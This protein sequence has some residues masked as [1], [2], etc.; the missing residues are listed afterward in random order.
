MSF[1]YRYRKQIIICLIIF[2]ILGSG[3]GGLFFFN[4]NFKKSVKKEKVVLSSE[5][6]PAIKKTA[7]NKTDTNNKKILKVDIKGEVINPGLYSLEEGNRVSDVIQMAGG[8]SENGD[9]TVINLSKKIKDEMVI[10]IYSKAEVED[11]KKTTEIMEQVIDNCKNSY[12]GIR[13]D[14]CIESNETET[15]NE[16]SDSNNLISINNATL[17]EL[18]TLPG[19]GEAKA[20][21]IIKY[22]EEHGL[23]SDINE[24]KNIDGI[25]DSIFDKIKE[26]ITL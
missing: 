1:K 8:L 9:T 15:N 17:E 5:K 14:A 18:Q 7:T 3:I 13:N 4:K 20:Q 6:T 24:L 16:F 2:L 12:E 26:N 10:I 19:I 21:N 25:G 11:F 23:F 22:R